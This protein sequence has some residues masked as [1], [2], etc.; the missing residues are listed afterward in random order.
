MA[1]FGVNLGLLPGAM[2]EGTA[3][4]VQD[5][6][7]LEDGANPN[8]GIIGELAMASLGVDEKIFPASSTTQ[9]YE[10]SICVESLNSSDDASPEP[11]EF[12]P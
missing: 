12:A 6:L 1:G 8:P 7:P 3:G 2:T 11:T 10:V 9:I 5:W 4:S